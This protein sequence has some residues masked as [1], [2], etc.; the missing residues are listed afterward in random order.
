MNK[1]ANFSIIMKEGFVI[2][3]QNGQQDTNND[4]R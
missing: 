1:N 3:F 2:I 4:N